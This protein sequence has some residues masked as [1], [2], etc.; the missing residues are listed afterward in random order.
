[1]RTTPGSG[2]TRSVLEIFGG[3]VEVEVENDDDDGD[4]EIDVDDVAPLPMA[5]KI[6]RA[7]DSSRSVAQED[8]AA[9]RRSTRS[10]AK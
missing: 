2:A 6:S 10:I 7:R 9:A 5:G 3:V 1:M 4:D 8:D